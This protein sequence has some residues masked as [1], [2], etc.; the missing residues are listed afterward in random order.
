MRLVRTGCFT[1]LRADTR[2]TIILVVWRIWQL[3]NDAMHG[4]EIPHLEISVEFLCS[5]WQL[6][7]TEG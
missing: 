5:Y 3:W 6:L 7:D 1:S 4:K 2:S